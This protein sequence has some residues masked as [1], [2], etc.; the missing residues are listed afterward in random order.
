MIVRYLDEIVN[1]QINRWNSI[2]QALRY[3]PGAREAQAPEG[4]KSGQIHPVICIS[5][6]LGSGARV[7]AQEVCRRLGYEIFGSAII[8]EIAKDLKVQRKLVDCLDESGQGSLEM[9]LE[10][11]LHGRELESQE[12]FTSLVR[13]INT[14]AMKGGVVLFGRGSTFILK[15]KS[16]LNVLVVA[17][18]ELRVRRLS[19]YEKLDAK[20]ARE[21]VLHYD[22]ERE[23]FVHRYFHENIHSPANFD[24]AINTDR[25]APEEGAKLVFAALEARGLSLERLAIAEAVH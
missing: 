6:E 14:L 13:V 2:T 10:T 18:L 5:R 3:E 21:K 9:I 17:P 23:A 25:V 11:F 8:D 16:A 7:I 1:R 19:L 22:R 4:E 12:Y 15:Q 20:S 24:L